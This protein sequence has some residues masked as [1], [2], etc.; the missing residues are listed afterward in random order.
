MKKRF[1]IGLLLICQYSFSQT[2]IGKWVTIDDETGNKKAIVEL[3]EDHGK[4]FGKIIDILEPEKRR[5]KCTKCEGADKDKPIL[6]LN[7]IKGMSKTEDGY[8]GGE[9]T[10]PKNG[11][12]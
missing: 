3:F 4:L 9:I 11:K 7:I 6:G 12:T 8:E 2:I 1:V 5:Q 10:D